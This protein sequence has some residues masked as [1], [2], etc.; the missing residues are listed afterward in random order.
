MIAN[1]KSITTFL[2]FTIASLIGLLSPIAYA[3]KYTIYKMNELEISRLPPFCQVW[4]RG[5]TEQ[6]DQ[7]VAKLKISNIHH[8]CKGL[9]HVNHANLRSYN[10][11]D[12][13]L[14]YHIKSG[15]G[16]FS[17]VL[18]H[19]K[20]QPFPL[21]SFVYLNRAKLH[22]IS[23]DIIKSIEDYSFSIKSNPKYVKAY[24]G[25]IDLYIKIGDK[26]QAAITLKKGLHN[27]PKSN[28]LLKKKKMLN[29]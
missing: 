24:V 20:G 11:K 22:E 2:F 18:A 23:G 14:G 5:D 27:A 25:L 6:T 12:N 28:I 9:N 16:E 7:W 8:L 15:I 1:N 4:A 19:A 10:N 29:M 26:E 21:R 17:Y 13:T 3:T